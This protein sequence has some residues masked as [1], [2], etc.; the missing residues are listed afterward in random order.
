MTNVRDAFVRVS[1]EL[2]RRVFDVVEA[3]TVEVQ[4]RDDGHQQSYCESFYP[5]FLPWFFRSAKGSRFSILLLTRK[6]IMFDRAR[7]SVNTSSIHG[8]CI[9]VRL[10]FSFFSLVAGFYFFCTMRNVLTQPVLP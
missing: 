9:L 10:S 8:H 1:V 5:Y 7:H 3:T 2:R 6:R 4:L